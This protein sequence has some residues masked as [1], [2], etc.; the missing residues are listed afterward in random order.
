L[1][2]PLAASHIPYGHMQRTA[3]GALWRVGDQAAVIPSFCG[4]G[5]AIALHS[6]ALAAEHF[7]AGSTP[8]A[9]Q[10]TLHGQ[11]ARRLFAATRLSQLIVA[12]PQAAQAVRLF[13]LLLSQIATMTRIPQKALITSESVY[14]S[15]LHMQ[16][17]ERR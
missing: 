4:D 11:L 17:Q 2:T 5:M 3:Q 8:H 7:I 14:P 10:R 13:P 12:W 9:Y 1:E 15:S 16:A 6:A